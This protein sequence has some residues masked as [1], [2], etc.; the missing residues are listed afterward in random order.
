ME[1]KN[2]FMNRKASIMDILIWII[3]A[4]VTLTFF[5]VWIYGHNILTSTLTSIESKDTD[6]VNISLAA[7]QTFGAIN[8]HLSALHTVALVII[9][10]LGISMLISNFLVKAHP[11]F[12][13]AYV[14]I[15]IVAIIFAVSI[16]NEYQTLMTHETIGTTLSGFR[17]GGFIMEYLPTWTTIFGLAGALFLFIGIIRDRGAGE[18]I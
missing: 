3:V 18:S 6:L 2:I 13:I 8:S 9:F 7:T 11:V 16:S 10:M 15:V 4:F 17:G 5:A 12:F 14:F 1:K